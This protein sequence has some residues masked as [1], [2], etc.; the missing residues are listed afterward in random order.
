MEGDRGR[1]LGFMSKRSGGRTEESPFQ[2]RN[3]MQV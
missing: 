3:K 2:E 1:T